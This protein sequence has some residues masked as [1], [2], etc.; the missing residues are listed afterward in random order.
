MVRQLADGYPGALDIPGGKVGPA[1]ALLGIEVERDLRPGLLVEAGQE[2]FGSLQRGC[3]AGLAKGW[4]VLGGRHQFALLAVA[5]FLRTTSQDQ[6]KGR[7]HCCHG[8]RFHR[9]YSLR[10]LTV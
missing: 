3:S 10:A 7:D 8:Y 2:G 5:S 9:E 6:G 4:I 1:R